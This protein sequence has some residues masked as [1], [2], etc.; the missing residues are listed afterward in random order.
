MLIAFEFNG[1]SFAI[2]ILVF[3]LFF[4]FLVSFSGRTAESFLA[5]VLTLGIKK[6]CDQDLSH[7]LEKPRRISLK[8]VLSWY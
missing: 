3:F 4:L 5:N 6:A 8:I 2:A 7:S 1:K